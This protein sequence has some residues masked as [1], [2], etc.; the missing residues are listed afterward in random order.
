MTAQTAYFDGPHRQPGTHAGPN[1][2]TVPRT[3][4]WELVPARSTADFAVRNFGFATV[5]GQIPVT[6]AWVDVDPAGQPAAVHAELDLTRVDTGNPRRDR[7]LRQPRLLDTAHHPTL[8]FDGVAAGPTVDGV[9]NGRAAA[10]VSLG[11]TGVTPGDGGIVTARATCAF[12]RAALGVRAPRLLIGRR[13]TVV[14]N[15][16]FAP[17]ADAGG[18]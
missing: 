6:A 15:A 10:D 18:R 17:P 1:T 12:D 2:V 13:I 7:D 5:R 9:L 4:R 16:T 8:T 3:G 14:I 11:V